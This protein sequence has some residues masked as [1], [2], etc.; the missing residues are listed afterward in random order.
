MLERPPRETAQR[1]S[2]LI[3]H[4]QKEPD[5]GNGQKPASAGRFQRDRGA[6]SQ[7][8]GQEDAVVDPVVEHEHGSRRHQSRRRNEG[9]PIAQGKKPPE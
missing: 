5:T 7:R 9:P 3:G 1:R 6:A 8:Q 4:G 2:G